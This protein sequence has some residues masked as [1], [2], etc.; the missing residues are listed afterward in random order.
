MCFGYS[1]KQLHLIPKILDQ[2]FVGSKVVIIQEIYTDLLW[3]S[4]ISPPPERGTIEMPSVLPSV[5]PS[6]R[7][8]V[9]ILVTMITQEGS[10]VGF[11]NLYQACIYKRSRTSSG[12]GDLD[13]KVK[14][15][16]HFF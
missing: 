6:F 8:S 4:L 7:P 9:Q 5:L 10:H 2:N 12:S 1:L 3:F 16:G 13:L 15:T 14:V 11:S